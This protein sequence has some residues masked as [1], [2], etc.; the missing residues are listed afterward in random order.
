MPNERGDYCNAAATA[1]L[2]LFLIACPGGGDPAR[3]KPEPADTSTEP[4]D[5]VPLPTESCNG[6]D[7]DGDGQTDEDFPDK[8]GNGR[9]DC[10]DVECPPPTTGV[11]QVVPVVS[12]C[13][14]TQPA[15]G[16]VEDPWSM[17]E[18]WSY[19]GPASDPEVYSAYAAPVVANLD[20]DD[21]SGAID[22]GDT[23]EVLAM[24][25]SAATCHVIALDGA[26]GTE[27]WVHSADVDYSSL[28]AAD[29]DGD[30]VPE[31]ITA[32]A[33]RHVL[34]LDADG[35]ERWTS[36]EATAGSYSQLSVADL[37]GDGQPEI[38]HN[39]QVLSGIDGDLLW[40]A[41]W[42]R[43]YCGSTMAA[44]GDVD[45]ADDDQELAFCGSLYDSDGTELW[46]SGNQ[47]DYAFWVALLQADSDPEAEL[48][49]AG[50]VFSVWDADGTARVEVSFDTR[51]NMALPICG[52]DFDGDGSAEVVVPLINELTMYELDGTLVWTVP[53]ASGAACAGFDVN[54]DGILEVLTATDTRFLILSGTTGTVLA[55]V[56]VDETF[57][58]AGKY[59]VPADID[60][61]G[62]AEIVVAARSGGV[63]RVTAY[64]HAGSG[65]PPAGPTWNTHDFSVT[66]VG[67][68]GSVPRDPEQPWLRHG[69][70]RARPAA[71]DPGLPDLSVTI[72]DACVA[73]CDYG[74]VKLAIQV[75]NQGTEDVAA[76]VTLSV[77]A[78][79]A[80]GPR[81]VA[82]EYLPDLPAAWA[83]AGI[84]L[85]LRAEDVG[86]RGLS[87]VVDGPDDGRVVECDETN[88]RAEWL[89][90]YCP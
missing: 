34:V 74:P 57:Y 27:V 6:V 25:C 62:H 51:A 49:F 61:D 45:D 53:D 88:N 72:T 22:A 89:A 4:T 28:V 11:A 10:L 9:V 17:V 54:A 32:T 46:E 75:I 69:V 44:I 64:A 82:T 55:E 65:W 81:L 29:L 23:P 24:I 84:E 19:T 13:V 43:G 16:E 41:A 48:V 71:D 39:E 87:V 70:Y 21:G 8:N 20:D 42:N 68:D 12:S 2:A 90:D 63:P 33:E 1:A 38:I 58:S 67:I 52:G 76:G 14:G 78:E 80:T 37:D 83:G 7:D 50:D 30:G 18:R 15:V 66:N 60:G 77:Y 73:D 35:Q 47:G 40:E 3:P 36:I 79:D 56:P 59:P 5:S 85:E 86:E 31:V 26:T